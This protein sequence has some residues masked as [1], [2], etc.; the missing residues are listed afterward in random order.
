MPRPDRTDGL[1]KRGC[2]SS[3]N[4]RVLFMSFGLR[5]MRITK[6]ERIMSSHRTNDGVTMWGITEADDRSA[7]SILLI[8]LLEEY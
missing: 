2:I 5:R 4:R 7:T 6:G 1:T 3:M 8:L